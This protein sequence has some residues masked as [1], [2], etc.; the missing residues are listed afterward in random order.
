MAEELATT[1]RRRC[2]FETMFPPHSPY[3]NGSINV[4]TSE[5][6][7]SPTDI[8][9][10]G[11]TFNV[12]VNW[13]LHGSLEHIICGK[14]C[15]CLD[16]ECVGAGPEYDVDEICK[17]IEFDC[18]QHG[19]FGTKFEVRVGDIPDTS[20]DRCSIVCRLFVTVSLVD[21]CGK[22]ARVAGF[23]EGPLVQF[24]PGE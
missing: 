9:F 7:I 15:V 13:E 22:P 3:L 21:N 5:D 18:H 11:E 16:F 19:V 12:Y 1:Y 23:C 17:Y 4:S 6:G 24:A 14:W 8:V 20:K 10:P 2:E